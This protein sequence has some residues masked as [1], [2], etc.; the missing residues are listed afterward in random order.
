MTLH[1]D[2][3]IGTVST[4]SGIILRCACM[5]VVYCTRSVQLFRPSG[6]RDADPRPGPLIPL[7]PD[8]REILFI[9]DTVTLHPSMTPVHH[10]PPHVGACE[11]KSCPLYVLSLV[12]F[13]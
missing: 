13:S 7:T 9:L 10:G 5:C 3:H 11:Y 12:P 4:L 6:V 1:R 2:G 8:S